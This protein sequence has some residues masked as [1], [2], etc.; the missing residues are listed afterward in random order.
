MTVGGMGFIPERL[1]MMMM[2]N[3]CAEFSLW[4]HA[5]GQLQYEQ[6]HHVRGEIATRL[7]AVL[8]CVHGATELRVFTVVAFCAAWNGG[9]VV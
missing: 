1:L 3:I 9:G 5:H 8:W 2:N 6:R 7:H 4:V